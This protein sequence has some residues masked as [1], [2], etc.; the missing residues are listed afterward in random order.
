MTKKELLE[1]LEKVD[2]NTEI[3]TNS[4]NYELSNH[5]VKARAYVSKASIETKEFRDDFDG[6]YYNSDVYV[7]NSNGKEVVVIYGG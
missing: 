5:N 6:T 1:V 4:N 7:S 3:I 2:D